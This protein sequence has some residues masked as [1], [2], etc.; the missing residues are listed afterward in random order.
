MLTHLAPPGVELDLV[1]IRRQA[2]A[3]HPPHPQHTHGQHPSVHVV[4]GDAE[5]LG[6]S[7]PGREGVAPGTSEAG[8]R[9]STGPFWSGLYN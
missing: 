3:Q 2:M 4:D 8:G 1:E 5:A 6:A 7:A 9:W